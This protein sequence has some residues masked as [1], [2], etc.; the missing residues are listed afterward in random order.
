MPPTETEDGARP[1][2]N[3]FSYVFGIFCFRSLLCIVDI[4]AISLNIVDKYCLG[5]IQVIDSNIVVLNC[6]Y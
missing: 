4:V 5:Y 2:A 1:A 3:V 6:L